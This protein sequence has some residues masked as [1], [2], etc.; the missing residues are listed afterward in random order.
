MGSA[1]L[2][3]TFRQKKI[4]LHEAAL[5][6]VLSGVYSL[7]SNSAMVFG[8]SLSASKGMP[9]AARNASSSRPSFSDMAT[10]CAV[11]SS[12]C[13]FSAAYVFLCWMSRALASCRAGWDSTP[14]AI[15][16]DRMA[17]TSSSAIVNQY[18]SSRTPILWLAAYGL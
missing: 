5:S 8:S 12:I 17:A 11:S 15:R 2:A 14:V 3:V 10:P 1:V 6:V 4:P 18:S 7:F 13:A 16:I 9:L